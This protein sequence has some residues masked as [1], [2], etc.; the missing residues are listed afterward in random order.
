[1]PYGLDTNTSSAMGYGKKEPSYLGHK[2]I[3]ERSHLK[4]DI[5]SKRKNLKKMW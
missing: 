3:F 4:G 2:S 5:L 1:M